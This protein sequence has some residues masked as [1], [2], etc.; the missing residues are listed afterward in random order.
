MNAKIIEEEPCITFDCITNESEIIKRSS[1][2][3]EFNAI[4]KI[5]FSEQLKKANFT[6]SPYKIYHESIDAPLTSTLVEFFHPRA[7]LRYIIKYKHNKWCS[8][9]KCQTLIKARSAHVSLDLNCVTPIAKYCLDCAQLDNFIT[10]V[11]SKLPRYKK[12]PYKT[13]RK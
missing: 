2:T 5:T 1:E 11:I 8:N 13:S 10:L 12:G 9:P 6:R 7:R 4:T 3:L